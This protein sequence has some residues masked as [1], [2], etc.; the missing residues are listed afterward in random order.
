MKTDL[1]NREFNIA[2][3]KKLNEI[4]ENSGSSISSGIK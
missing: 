4:R 2:V 3:M 1:N